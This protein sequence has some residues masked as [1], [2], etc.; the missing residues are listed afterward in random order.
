M[1][2]RRKIIYIIFTVILSVVSY[3]YINTLNELSRMR[4]GD[5]LENA[6]ETKWVSIEPQYTKYF[7]QTEKAKTIGDNIVLFQS[8]CG[9][10][11]KDINYD[12]E[13]DFWD[14]IYINRI[15]LKTIHPTIDNSATTTEIDYLAKLYKVTSNNK[16]KTSAIKGVQYLLDIQM[17][18]GGFPQKYPIITDGYQKN[19]TYNDR[20]MINVLS[21]FKNILKN[22][23]NQYGFVEQSMKNRLQISIEK[24]IDC[25]LK[26]Q[27]D[28]GI[29]SAQYDE[30]TLQ[31]APARIYEPIAADTRESADIVLFLMDIN[32]PD[33]RI[34]SAIKKAVGWFEQNLI[35]DKV[36]MWYVRDDGQKDLK[37]TE[38]HGENMWGR[39]YDIKTQKIIFS[40]KTGQIFENF[41]NI[42]YERR[43]GYEWFSFKGN[44]VLKRYQEWLNS[45]PDELK[46]L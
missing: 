18:N 34:V 20:A 46:N 30:Q 33:K 11:G 10:W 36:V 35:N 2:K 14:K 45:L 5:L 39:F 13:N 12:R 31:P 29:W 24:G 19:V 1:F 8:E 42:K 25:I 37:I 43:L 22:N 44:K 16:Y 26:T 41:D 28:I 40:D 9:G 4:F 23:E 6:Y 15:K 17:N 27:L 21:L 38:G 7:Y 3:D 32:S